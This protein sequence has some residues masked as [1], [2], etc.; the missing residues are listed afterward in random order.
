MPRYVKI[1]DP[2]LRANFEDPVSLAPL[3]RPIKIRESDPPHVF[4]Y[5][6][7][8]E[9][10]RTAK[11]D[12]ISQQTLGPEWAIPDYQKDH[13]LSLATASV[14]LTYGGECCQTNYLGLFAWFRSIAIKHFRCNH[15]DIQLQSE[16]PMNSVGF[17]HHLR[18]VLSQH[19]LIV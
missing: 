2:K 8:M 14:P 11:Y 13:E 18:V 19:Q 16:N 10:T 6:I 9:I 4:S 1:S 17:F 7:I 5:P 15:T 12:P 3:Y